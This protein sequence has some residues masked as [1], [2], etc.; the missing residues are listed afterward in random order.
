VLWVQQVERQLVSQAGHRHAERLALG[1]CSGADGSLNLVGVGLQ[2]GPG[3]LAAPSR[4][5]WLRIRL[6]T[7]Y[8]ACSIAGQSVGPPRSCGSSTR[9]AVHSRP[10][11][12]ARGGRAP[13][14]LL[15]HGPSTDR[16]LRSPPF[17]EA[18]ALH[19]LRPGPDR[20]TVHGKTHWSLSQAIP[21]AASRAPGSGTW[22]L[23]LRRDSGCYQ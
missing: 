14:V 6:R 16:G 15:R 4:S 20:P 12:P 11:Q 21:L 18:S 5:R 23:I 17:A 22:L 9:G 13:M 3:G 19:P 8:L 10:A 7:F 1:E 2:H